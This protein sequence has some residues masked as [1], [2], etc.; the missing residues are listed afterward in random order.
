V[1]IGLMVLFLLLPY[2]FYDLL[3]EI[4]LNGQ[5]FGKKLMNI[6][7]IRIERERPSISNYLLRW[8]LHPIDIRISYGGVAI[9]TILVNGKG[10]RLG[11]LAAGTAVIKLKQETNLEDTILEQLDENYRLTFAEV[12]K[13][14]EEIISIVKEVLDFA[15]KNKKGST[16]DILKKT[17]TKLEEKMKINSG[18]DPLE[19]LKTVLLDYNYLHQDKK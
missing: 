15:K 9:I 18:L 4:F 17:K 11:D 16:E 13:L 7:V 1:I 6:K 2:F 12:R 10:Q 5:S 3:C 19:F 8:L 14:D